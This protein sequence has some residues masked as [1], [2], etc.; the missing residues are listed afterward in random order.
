LL[1]FYE[2]QQRTINLLTFINTHHPSNTRNREKE[3]KKGADNIILNPAI[4]DHR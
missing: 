1:F 3:E 2:R 4:N